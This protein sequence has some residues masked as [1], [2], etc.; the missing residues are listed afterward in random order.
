MLCERGPIYRFFPEPDKSIYV[1]KGEDEEFSRREFF[2]RGHD[3]R[4]TRGAR[5]LGGFLGSK[6]CLEAW[7]KPMVEKWADAVRTLA[8]IAR[9]F[10]QT[11]F[12]GLAVS[13]QNEWQHVSRAIPDVGQYFDPIEAAICDDFLPALF[14]ID[15]IDAEFR[16][17]LSHSVTTAGIGIRNPVEAAP[18]AFTASKIACELLVQ[19][20]VDGDDLDLNAH[21]K[22]VRN[23]CQITRDTRLANEDVVRVNRGNALGEREARRLDRAC[24]TG[25]WLTVLPTRL[26]GTELSAEE[27]RDNLRLRY[28]LQ[29][30]NIPQKCDGCGCR[31]D[32]DHL[33]SCKVGGLV[34]ARH[35]GTSEVWEHLGECAFAPGRVS[36]EPKI[37]SETRPERAR[38]QR[39]IQP[40]QNTNHGANTRPNSTSA[41]LQTQSDQS[42]GDTAIMGFWKQ[43][44]KTIFDYRITDTDCRSYQNMAPEKVLEKMEG[45]KKGKYL[46][47]CLERRRDFTPMV[48]TVDGMPGKEARAAEKKMA[49]HLAAKWTRDYSEMCGYVRAQMSLNLI[50]ANTELL[51]GSRDRKN[52]WRPPHIRNGPAMMGWR[53]VQDL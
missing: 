35:D 46:E 36:H 21:H 7:I 44:R 37:H 30:D 3:V 6:G 11:A 29:L 22:K 41:P 28:G 18:A 1:C 43:G 2:A 52:E 48:Y 8:K 32:V 25:A 40:T 49:S 39:R 42:R 47:A 34:H 12:V 27:F 17:L 31:A 24:Q 50:R 51:R 23:S 14:G 9:R 15:H 5:Y 26:N 20:M 16:A 4:F 33:L 13:L 19:A 45:E 53:V 38:R 10:P